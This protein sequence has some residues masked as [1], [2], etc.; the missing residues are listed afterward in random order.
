MSERLYQLRFRN[1]ETNAEMF[2]FMNEDNY[3]S[4]YKEKRT[5]KSDWEWTGLSSFI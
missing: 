4:W 1:V 5:V 2:L 3:S